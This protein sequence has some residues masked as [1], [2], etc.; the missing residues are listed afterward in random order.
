MAPSTADSRGK[1]ADVEIRLPADGAYVSVLRTTTAAIAARLDLTIDDIEDLRVAVGEAGALL[2]PE[3]DPASDLLCR[4]YLRPG[5][6]TVALGVD[7]RRPSA[8]DRES[9]AWQVLTTL[10][11]AT[12]VGYVDGRLV[13]TMTMSSSAIGSPG[14]A[15]GAGL[16]A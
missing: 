5:T 7:S 16:D 13:I 4:L 1:R 6:V 9:F 8:P 11:D 14:A 3:A 10:T 12:E 15:R 2:L